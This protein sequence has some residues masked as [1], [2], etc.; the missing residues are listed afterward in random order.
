ATCRRRLHGTAIKNGRRGLRSAPLRQ[1]Q[2]RTQIM[3]DGLQHPGLEPAVALLVHR[4]PGRQVMEHH[5]P[6]RT[7]AGNLAPTIEDLVPAMLAWRRIVRHEGQIRGHQGPCVMTDI[8][9]VR[10]STLHSSKIVKEPK[11]SRVLSTR[12]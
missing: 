2:D 1:L 10:L 5:P 6:R 3:D 11:L 4:R 8:T 12:Y 7:R 9:G